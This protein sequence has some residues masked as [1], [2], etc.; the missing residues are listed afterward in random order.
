MF[1]PIDD[2]IAQDSEFD[3]DAFFPVSLEAHRADGKLYAIPQEAQPFTLFVNTTVIGESGLALPD[4][5]WSMD[6]L[7]SIA[8]RTKRIGSQGETEHWGW[9]VEPTLTRAVPYIYAFGGRIL[10]ESGRDFALTSPQTLAGL[11]FIQDAN[12][13]SGVLGGNF[14]RGT[15]TFYLSGPW[16]VPRFRE[17]I[18]G[19]F[20][21]DILPV[22]GGPGG[23]G[24]TLG[25]DGYYVSSQSKNPEAAWK[26]L[27]FLASEE[28]QGRSSHQGPSSRPTRGR[29]GVRV[30]HPRRGSIQPRSLLGR[31]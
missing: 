26:F 1:S 8:Q 27:S 12:I 31:P 29:P 30:Q 22:P 28:S 9:L 25:S 5:D 7:L 19:L 16:H 21:W 3:L 24:T 14:G 4:M 13:V 17:S 20:D 11:Q 2:L 10:N 6:D 18:H 23:R 15:T